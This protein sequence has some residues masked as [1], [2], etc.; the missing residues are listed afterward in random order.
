[1]F[2]FNMQKEEKLKYEIKYSNKEIFVNPIEE[3]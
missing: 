3:N 1:M 2:K